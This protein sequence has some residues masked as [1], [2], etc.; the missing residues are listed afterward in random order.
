M[1][2]YIKQLIAVVAGT[3]LSVSILTAMTANAA[4]SGQLF[5]G[6]TNPDGAPY[7]E[8]LT[9]PDGSPYT[10][11]LTNP[12]GSP[13]EEDE[14]YPEE[15]ADPYYL[16]FVEMCQ[17]A[18]DGD[19]ITSYMMS[20]LPDGDDFTVTIDNLPGSEYPYE[21]KVHRC[22]WLMPADDLIGDE[23]GNNIG[24]YK[25]TD[26]AVT[27]GYN[28]S[29]DHIWVSGDGVEMV[30]V[31]HSLPDNSYNPTHP[32]V[33]SY[34]VQP[35]TAVE[36]FTTTP[37]TEPVTVLQKGDADG[38]GSVTITDATTVQMASAE[39]ITLT[40]AQRTAADVNKDGK[41]DVLDAT[42][43]QEYLVELVPGLD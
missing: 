43:I 13:Y 31:Y 4:T 14:T 29:T 40:D 6:L 15:I 17:P 5:T 11:P 35:S 32:V 21:F 1:K 25:R 27:I 42:M 39:L 18:L 23:N 3:A 28:E 41:V 19:K 22:S 36:P 8:P 33:T 7:T 10:E 12:D 24:F 38:S 2:K 26:G 34:P 16:H 9:N 37:A 30:Q 20:F